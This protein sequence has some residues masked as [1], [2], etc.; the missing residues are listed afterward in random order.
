M[1]DIKVTIIGVGGA[2]CNTINRLNRKN[3]TK[4]NLLAVNTDTQ[5]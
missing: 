1:S 4:Y 3:F 5:M 2:G